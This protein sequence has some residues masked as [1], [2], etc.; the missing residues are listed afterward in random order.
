MMLIHI[1]CFRNQNRSKL[2]LDL[3]TT[4]V[5]NNLKL[6]KGCLSYVL[7]PFKILTM[8]HLISSF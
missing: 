8:Y 5:K 2:N 4:Y 3:I 1:F 6:E 7:N